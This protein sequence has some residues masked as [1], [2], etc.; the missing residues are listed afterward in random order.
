MIVGGL[1]DVLI[2]VHR[3]SGDGMP[4]DL[5]A[6]TALAIDTVLAD[7]KPKARA[8]LAALLQ[9]GAARLLVVVDL[10]AGRAEVQYDD[11]GELPK[12]IGSV[13]L[14]PEVTH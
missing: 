2:C 6:T 13:V 7:L 1:D 11:G 9:A 10:L 8:N 5:C 12:R 3:L 4:D 14:V